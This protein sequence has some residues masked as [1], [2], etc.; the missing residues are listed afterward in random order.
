MKCEH[1]G[2]TALIAI[3]KYRKRYHKCK[4]TA[5]EL[6][7]TNEFSCTMHLKCEECPSYGMCRAFRSFIGRGDKLV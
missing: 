5:L 2:Y 4:C 1:H 7:Y 6:T 3:A